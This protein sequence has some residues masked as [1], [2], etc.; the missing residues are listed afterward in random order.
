M[1]LILGYEYFLDALINYAFLAL[2]GM[3]LVVR[4]RLLV[5]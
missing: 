2:N 1:Q 5:G 3:E 4:Q